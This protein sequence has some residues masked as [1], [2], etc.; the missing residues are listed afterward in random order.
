MGGK[1]IEWLEIS[2]RGENHP[3]LTVDS[4]IELFG[5]KLWG[6]AHK[7]KWNPS[8]Y[9][10]FD[11]ARWFSK[12]D[13]KKYQAVL[14]QG[15][16]K[17]KGYLLKNAKEYA[18]RITAH[19]AFVKKYKG[20]NFTKKTNQQLGKIF[21]EWFGHTKQFFCFAYDYIYLNKYMPE[22]VM[23]A[24]ARKEPD[25]IKQNECLGILF[26]ADSLSEMWHE[27]RALLSLAEIIKNRLL[28][29]NSDFVSKKIAN[30]LNKYAHLGF[31]YFRGQAYTPKEIINRLKQYIKLSSAQFKKLHH[32]IINQRTNKQQ[33]IR[34]ISQLGLD[35]QTIYKIKILKRWASLSNYVDETYSYVV[36]NLWDFWTE[37]TQRLNLNSVQ[38]MASFRGQEI[39]NYLSR[40]KVP[41][42]LRVI[43]RQRLK[44]HALVLENG[45]AGIYY[46]QQ[47]KKY[48]KF[49]LQKKKSFGN[50][51]ELKGQVASPGL[52]KGIVR[53][54]Y[55]MHDLKKVER[56]NI[57]VTDATNPTYVPAMERSA[58]VI[59]DEGGLLCHAAIV[60]R[61]LKI[62][63]VV[64]TEIGTRVFKDGEKVM[65]DA[66]RGIIRKI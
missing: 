30:H 3:L 65:V 44:D 66:K 28:Q 29:L 41:K 50:I 36:Y 12:E 21:Q 14:E 26:T 59:T 1:K 2:R 27:K 43:A 64:G 18:L 57:M 7:V 61:E 19:R 39:Y 4:L 16:Q 31:Y 13:M 56:G 49:S 11:D 10:Q 6:W 60:S 54:V 33:T 38:E 42:G 48:R 24:V 22:Q 20:V 51:K 5:L 58:A 53:V 52:V 35:P 25:V 17:Q 46:G 45:R 55:T 15:E 37:I 23:Q 9:R 62:P 8:C 34:L 40:K 63:C 47:M 32:D